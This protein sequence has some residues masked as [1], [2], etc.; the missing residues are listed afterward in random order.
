MQ[1]DNLSE[2][3]YKQRDDS[4]YTKMTK[5]EIAQ[6]IDPTKLSTFIPILKDMNYPIMLDIWFNYYFRHPT[7]RGTVGRYISYMRLLGIKPF[8]YNSSQFYYDM[9][10]KRK[11]Y[12]A[13]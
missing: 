9:I 5:D 11:E 3:Y 6:K 2:I 4:Y 7:S 8:D 1:T 12:N 13:K 10:K